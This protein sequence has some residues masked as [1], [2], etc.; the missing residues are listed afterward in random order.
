MKK[1]TPKGD[2]VKA[3]REQ[4]ERGAT[5][6]EF[7]YK[8][9]VGIRMLRKIE[10][11]NAPIPITVLEGMSR[12]LR[13]DKG[14]LVFALDAPKLVPDVGAPEAKASQF[15]FRWDKDQLIPRFDEDIAKVTMDAADLLAE[16]NSSEVVESVINVALNSETEIYAGELLQ[17]LQDVSWSQRSV[18]DELSDEEESELGKRVR[19]LLVLLKG[20]DVWV[21]ETKVYRRLPERDALPQEDEPSST[22]R[23][24]YVVFGQPG[25]YGENTVNVEVDNGH[26]FILKAWKTSQAVDVDR[27]T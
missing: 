24:L 16:A 8:I 9:G 13:V 23:R 7:A 18:L 10:N 15:S 11:E 1:F 27:M 26:P 14:E 22:E 2:V 20:N 25:E 6:K 19:Q 17:I 21:Y 5:Q 3:L 12:E 4:L